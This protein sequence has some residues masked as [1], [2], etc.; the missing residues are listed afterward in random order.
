MRTDTGPCLAKSP[1]VN[2]TPPTRQPHTVSG[3]SCR[4]AFS[5]LERFLNLL[6]GIFSGI[7][8]L[9]THRRHR[10]RTFQVRVGPTRLPRPTYPAYA[11]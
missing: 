2:M 5:S 3:S 6:A 1:M 4:P 8:R 7:K 10:Y 11:T 9:R